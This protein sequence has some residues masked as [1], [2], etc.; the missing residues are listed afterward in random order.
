MVFR[1]FDYLI[2]VESVH[3]SITFLK[4]W[5]NAKS[6]NWFTYMRCYFLIRKVLRFSSTFLFIYL[7]ITIFSQDARSHQWFS[8]KL[9]T[10][11]KYLLKLKMNTKIPN[12]TLST[13]SFFLQLGTSST[14]TNGEKLSAISSWA[15]ENNPAEDSDPAHFDVLSLIHRYNMCL[16]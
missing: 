10:C 2:I 4:C 1:F 7:F 6:R 3:L 13:F 15:G 14:A 16:E 12:L 5:I 8:E 11:Y 9:K